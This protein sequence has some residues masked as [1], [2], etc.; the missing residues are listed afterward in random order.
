MCFVS[1]EEQENALL[2]LCTVDGMSFWPNCFNYERM[3]EMFGMK[4]TFVLAGVK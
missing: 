1:E 2:V 4:Q 3:S